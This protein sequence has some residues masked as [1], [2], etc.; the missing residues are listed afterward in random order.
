MSTSPHPDAHHPQLHAIEH[1]SGGDITRILQL[2]PNLADETGSGLTEL[3]VH[4]E[5][6]VTGDTLYLKADGKYWKSDANSPDTMPV[7]A[8]SL[9]VTTAADATGLCLMIGT[10]RNDDRYNWTPGNGEANL[11]YAHTT[12]GELVQFA[13]KPVGA[14]DRVQVCG[15]IRDDNSIYF[16][17][18]LE[19]IEVP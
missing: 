6:S 14:G 5:N 3:L 4:G 19:L 11:L 2:N 18:S 15:Q 9:G 10:Y 8:L 12:P 17:P 7:V 13:N 1:E 16:N